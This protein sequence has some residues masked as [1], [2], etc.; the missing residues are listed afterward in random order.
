MVVIVVIVDNSVMVERF[1]MVVIADNFVMVV[2]T[3]IVE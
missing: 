1:V 3:V 2:I